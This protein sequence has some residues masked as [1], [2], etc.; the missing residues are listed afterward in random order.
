[1]LKRICFFI[2]ISLCLLIMACANEMVNDK[3]KSTNDET[4]R[5]E[6][7]ESNS[8]DFSNAENNQR[9]LKEIDIKKELTPK[10]AKVKAAIEEAEKLAEENIAKSENKGKSCN[11]II[12]EFEVLISKII[13]DKSNQELMTQLAKWNTDVLH[14]KCR[15][16]P[17]YEASFLKI[18]SRLN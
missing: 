18:I 17:E 7:S 5:I 3:P 11:E 15:K 2:P 16:D 4:E 14:N 12:K 13:N 8:E 6:L 1:M 10:P 9:S